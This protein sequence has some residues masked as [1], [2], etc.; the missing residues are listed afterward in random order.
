MRP[1]CRARAQLRNQ[2]A[3]HGQ[4]Q[5]ALRTE[6]VFL[7]REDVRESNVSLLNEKLK[8]DVRRAERGIEK[9]FCDAGEFMNVSNAT[10][11]TH[12][13]LNY[14][15]DSTKFQ[16]CSQPLDEFLQLLS[17][18]CMVRPAFRQTCDM[19]RMLMLKPTTRKRTAEPQLA[20]QLQN[21]EQHR[22]S[23]SIWTVVRPVTR[24][25][26]RN[27]DACEAQREW[28]S[29]RLGDGDLRCARDT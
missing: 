18:A 23:G 27:L 26:F 25:L 2:P 4:C 5:L 13:I 14:N 29:E 15:R 16:D 1:L 6:E 7:A 21:L 20:M 17:V 3:A 22:I 8:Q 10:S 24:L 12:H 9:L 11:W 19:G 28:C